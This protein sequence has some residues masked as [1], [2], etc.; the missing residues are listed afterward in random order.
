MRR[1]LFAAAVLGLLSFG[2]AGCENTESGTHTS[3]N[4]ATGCATCAKGKAGEAVWC[5]GCDAGY[6]SGTKTK[7]K[8]CYTAKTGGPACA[9]CEAKK[10]N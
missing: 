1:M 3:A 8:G 10:V 6:V 7:C 2:L 4:T 5:E 9:A